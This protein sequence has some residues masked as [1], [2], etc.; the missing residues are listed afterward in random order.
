MEC[1][2]LDLIIDHKLSWHQ[3]ANAIFKNGQPHIFTFLEI[4]FLTLTTKFSLYFTNLIL[5]VCFV[6]VL[7]A[8][9]DI[10]KIIQKNKLGKIVKTCVKIMKEQKADLY[11]LYLTKLTER[12]RRSLLVKFQPFLSGQRYRSL[13]KQKTN[14][15]L[16]NNPIK[17]DVA[18]MGCQ[19]NT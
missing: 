7:Y 10:P 2:Y 13:T 6:I 12:Q 3:C 9:M 19:G 17:Q 5:R 4:L 11:H 14:V 16:G 8:D 18:A 15:L 1:K